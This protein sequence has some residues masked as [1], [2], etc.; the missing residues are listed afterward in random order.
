ME[1]PN[2]R[3]EVFKYGGNA[4]LM[5]YKAVLYHGNAVIDT[6]FNYSA[7]QVVRDLSAHPAQYSPGATVAVVDL[8]GEVL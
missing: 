8:T 7:A 6:A 1:S 2:Y 3:I 5:Q 4:P